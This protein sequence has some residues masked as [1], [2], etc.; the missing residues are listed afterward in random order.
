[1]RLGDFLRSVGRTVSYYPRL[2]KI[3]GGVE[4]NVFLCQMY[5][6][7]GKQ[8]DPDGWIYKTQAEIE[9][10]TGINP[11]SQRTVRDRLK[12]RGLLEERFKGIPRKLEFRVNPDAL[13]ERWQF[14]LEHGEEPNAENDKR[15]NN[16]PSKQCIESRKTQK[17]EISIDR[18]NQ[19]MEIEKIN[20]SESK[21]S[22]AV[23]RKNRSL[24]EEKIDLYLYTEKT[25]K[26][27]SEITTKS[28]PTPTSQE[29]RPGRVLDQGA[30]RGEENPIQMSLASLLNN[31]GTQV[32]AEDPLLEQKE[33]ARSFEIIEQSNNHPAKRMENRFKQRISEQQLRQIVFEIYNQEKPSNFVNHKEINSVQIKYI[34][35][36]MSEYPDGV[37]DIF[38]N[39][40]I[41]A[42]ESDN[43]WWR[44]RSPIAI[45]NLL[46]DNKALQYSDKHLHAMETDDRYRARVEGRLP[47]KDKK[48]SPVINEFGQEE[49]GAIADAARVYATDEMFRM[50]MDADK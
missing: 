23:D 32:Q 12:R 2:A 46:S 19:S 7:E 35:K 6:W 40:L 14:F 1:M 27:T 48:R 10:E 16:Y 26:N 3:T 9:E 47:S 34:K 25:T 22:I 11:D 36:I 5:F 41:W 20:S 44:V 42:R 13:E 8:E 33:A 17:K 21:K 45:E 29:E 18:K 39:A 50:L 43:D 31:P 28:T 15:K 24:D 49:T 37:L 38:R 30:K 4:A